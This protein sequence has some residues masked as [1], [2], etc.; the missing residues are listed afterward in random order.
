M[1]DESVGRTKSN[2]SKSE[3]YLAGGK[4]FEYLLLNDSS[5]LLTSLQNDNLD[6]AAA[7]ENDTFSTKS[8]FLSPDSPKVTSSP[9]WQPNSLNEGWRRPKSDL[10]K[11]AEGAKQSRRLLEGVGRDMKFTSTTKLFSR[12][13]DKK[14]ENFAT[15]TSPLAA[16]KM[17]APLQPAS[18]MASTP[19]VQKQSYDY[20]DSIVRLLV[21]NGI[22]KLENKSV[23]SAPQN[24]G[25]V[26]SARPAQD[27][28]PSA[29]DVSR[30]MDAA[31]GHTRNESITRILKS[32]SKPEVDIGK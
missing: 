14:C 21:S 9:R 11:S 24:G 25:S 23:E 29:E 2:P 18:K 20:D 31:V 27:A 32:S 26:G 19:A 16:N 10:S 7:A 4:H 30:I 15:F 6:A 13:A 12:Q 22:L 1:N 5:V 3:P 17:A 8:N 28:N